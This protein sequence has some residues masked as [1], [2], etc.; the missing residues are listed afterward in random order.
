MSELC[1]D[2]IDLDKALGEI[3]EFG[4]YQRNN[5]LLLFI[6]ILLVTSYKLS[7]IFTASQLEYRYKIF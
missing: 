2:E 7:F 4:K 3:G 5:F 6:P 1:D